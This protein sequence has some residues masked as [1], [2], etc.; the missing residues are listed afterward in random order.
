MFSYL[1]SF[2]KPTEVFQWVGWPW[3]VTFRRFQRKIGERLGQK[4]V[5]YFFFVSKPGFLVGWL[6]FGF[7]FCRFQYYGYMFSNPKLRLEIAKTPYS[8]QDTCCGR[9]APIFLWG[10]YP[11]EEIPLT[12]KP[13][14][15][16]IEN[17]KRWTKPW[18]RYTKKYY[19]NKN[20]GAFRRLGL[21]EH[22][23]QKNIFSQ[24]AL[25]LYT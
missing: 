7:C 12:E 17:A 1:F 18:A 13:F 2:S 25:P 15:C 22:I 9:G 10:S 3:V 19:V 6:A 16:K 11:L 14:F 21:R 5:S 20:N 8:G 24:K 4:H 23:V